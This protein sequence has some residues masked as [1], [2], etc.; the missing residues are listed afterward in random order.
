MDL[1]II[2]VKKRNSRYIGEVYWVLKRLQIKKIP[3][4]HAHNYTLIMFNCSGMNF[5]DLVKLR[6][7]QMANDRI[8]YWR[9]K[10]GDQLP[11]RITSELKRILAIYAKG[12]KSEEN[13]FPAIYDGSTKSYEKYKFLRRRMNGHL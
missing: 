4:W 12:K 6:V 2:I 5:I 10:T 7:K 1:P 8:F 11:V 13:L 3:I 9:S